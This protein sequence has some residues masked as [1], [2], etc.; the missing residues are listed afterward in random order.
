MWQRRLYRFHS[1]LHFWTHFI[2]LPL[3]LCPIHDTLPVPKTTGPLHVLISLSRKVFMNPYTPAHSTGPYII[4]WINS[5]S[6]SALSSKITCS[7]KSCLIFPLLYLLHVDQSGFFCNKFFWEPCSFFFFS[8]KVSQLVL[9]HYLCDHLFI[10]YLSHFS[11]STTR[12]RTTLTFTNQDF[13]RAWRGADTLNRFS[14]C[15]NRQGNTTT[16]I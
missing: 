7:K 13:P 9:T 14:N 6:D 1:C 8:E 16:R 2:S 4:Y 3:S 12:A 15:L 5:Y 11:V 10:A